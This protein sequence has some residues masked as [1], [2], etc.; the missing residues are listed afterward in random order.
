MR[1]H[2]L[3]AFIMISAPVAWAQEVVS[4]PA[5][6]APTASSPLNERAAWCDDYATWLVMM[7]P[8]TQ[9]AA[10][11]DVRPT[12]HL[13]VELNACKVDPQQYERETRAEAEH[14][15]AIAQG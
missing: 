9:R 12:Q 14:A 6:P 4:P 1:T 2:I 8:D 3:A 7:T 5:A 15:I 10:P 13:E 11:S